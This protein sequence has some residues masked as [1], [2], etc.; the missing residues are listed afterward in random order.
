MALSTS[1]GGSAGFMYGHD[2]AA[3]KKAHRH[4]TERLSSIRW[5][6]ATRETSPG[7]T[8][9]SG[10]SRDH[11]NTASRASARNTD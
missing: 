6:I 2:S 4:S 1:M 8:T 9:I 7:N 5:L 11:I 10:Q 3:Q